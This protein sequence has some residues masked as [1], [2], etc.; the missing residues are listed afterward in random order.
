MSKLSISFSLSYETP[1]AALINSHAGSLRVRLVS[2]WC[3]CTQ[4]SDVLGEGATPWET[5]DLVPAAAADATPSGEASDDSPYT[6]TPAPRFLRTCT[7]KAEVD[8][9]D[10]TSRDKLEALHTAPGIYAV[11]LRQETHPLTPG[12]DGAAPTPGQEPP[13]EQ[14]LAPV[15]FVYCDCSRFLVEAGV[16]SAA[17]QRVGPR[18]RDLPPDTTGTVGTAV[19][20]PPPVD[21]ALLPLPSLTVSVTAALLP[22]DVSTSLEP[23]VLDFSSLGGYP[24]DPSPSSSGAAGMQDLLAATVGTGI[25]IGT[26]AGLAVTTSGVVSGASFISPEMSNAYIYG[27]LELGG[28]TRIVHA[29]PHQAAEAWGSSDDIGPVAEMASQVGA[30]SQ[31]LAHGGRGGGGVMFSTAS[32][33]GVGALRDPKHNHYRLDC[34]V[35]V[36]PGL[37]DLER[38]KEA[39]YS[40]SLVMQLHC[41]D[42]NARAFHPRAC[43]EYHAALLEASS[44]SSFSSAPAAAAP[45]AKAPAKG[46]PAPASSSSPTLAQPAAFTDADALLLSQINRALQVG[47]EIANHGT[48]QVRL[49]QL[50]RQSVDLLA[51]FRR[52]RA[53]L[54]EA[55]AIDAGDGAGAGT[56]PEHEHVVVREDILAEVRVLR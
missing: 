8:L 52:R 5:L 36:L 39:L 2:E 48:G 25:G 31:G 26:G 38:F 20:P 4:L 42:V 35:V 54:R 24:V 46:A 41:E 56:E 44:S 11:V 55:G 6:Y 30:Q 28:S 3:S 37:H 32:T 34:R 49:E 43:Q 40:S 45:A 21:L 50:L 7:F 9:P 22:R 47:S 29:R 33:L 13:T 1:D 16:I 12:P 14:R 17:G 15:S 53:G 27:R 18:T 19:A 51:E 23:L 10:L